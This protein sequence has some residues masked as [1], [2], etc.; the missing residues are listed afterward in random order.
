ML[1]TWPDW[2]KKIAVIF[3][4]TVVTK[5]QIVVKHVRFMKSMA[6]NAC[7]KILIGKIVASQGIRGELRV[8]TFTEKP[9]DLKNLPVFG[10]NIASSNFHFVRPVPNTN[11]IIARIDGVN[12]RNVAET[13]RGTP[14]FVSRDNLPELKKDG[15]YYQS[16]LVGFSVV[17]NGTVL[18]KI[19]CFQNFGAGDIMELENGDMVSFRD[20]E[21]NFEKELVIVK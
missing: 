6:E 13:L 19:V 20:A 5:Y 11:V 18:G 9:V 10:D 8:Q 17:R 3:L 4:P 12:D 1:L 2:H 7:K 15:E 16:D 14:L 21:V